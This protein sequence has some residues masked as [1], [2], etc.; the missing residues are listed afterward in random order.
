V[1]PRPTPRS[2]AP[3]PRKPGRRVPHL[4]VPHLRVPHLRGPQRRVPHLRRPHLRVPRPDVRAR[5]GA[6]PLHLLGFLISLAI[7]GLAIRRIFDSDATN[8]REV[9]EWFLGGVIAHD[10]I[11]LPLY[12]GLDR[13][14]RSLGSWA[15]YV[16]VPAILAGL[17]FLVFFPLILH[18]GIGDYFDATGLNEDPYLHRWLI[19]SAVLVAL[20]G[21][22]ATAR[23][24][25][26]T[27]RR[28]L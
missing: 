7:V 21:L 10:L 27:W 11:F 19:A 14:I 22:A 17:L 5:Y 20:S 16:R 25:R 8:T 12:S 23:G 4:R 15:A 9:I 26:L 3:A 24:A 18:R 13:G 1:A 6:S 28:L 2:G